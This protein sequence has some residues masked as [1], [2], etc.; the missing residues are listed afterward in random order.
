MQTTP[1]IFHRQF[2]INRD[3]R[4]LTCFPVAGNPTPCAG[5]GAARNPT[6]RRTGRLQRSLFA[7]GDV[8]KCLMPAFQPPGLLAIRYRDGCRD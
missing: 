8:G 6:H 4:L 5:I 3:P 2:A 7:D 1:L